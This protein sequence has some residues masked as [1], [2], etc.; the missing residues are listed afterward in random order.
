VDESA[1]PPERLRGRAGDLALHQA[2][3]ARTARGENYYD[4]V[5]VELQARGYPTGSVFNWRTPFPV[6]VLARIPPAWGRAILF[7]IGIAVVV[8]GYL[9]LS[10]ESGRTTAAWGAL[11]LLGGVLPCPVNGLTVMSELWAGAL[12]ALSVVCYG[13]RWPA[14]GKVTALLALFCRELAAPY[15]VVCIGLA[16]RYRQ[17]RE[18]VG[19]ALGLFAYAAFYTWHLREVLPRIQPGAP[20]HAG[21]WIALGGLPFVLA[22]VQMN[23]FLFFLPIATAAV[24]PVAAALG[25]ASWTSLAGQRAGLTAGAYVAAFAVVGQPFNQY[26]GSV[27][28]PLLCLRVA[29]CPLALRALWQ[30]ATF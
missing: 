23:G 6:L 3:R 29:R 1:R 2:T 26:W 7:T 4:A 17:W 12:I 22:T 15:W 24:Y 14:A 8:L 5:G 9:W 21:S 13:H 18:A 30:R 16:I 19:L 11:L 20:T 10:V 28:A 27:T 25:F